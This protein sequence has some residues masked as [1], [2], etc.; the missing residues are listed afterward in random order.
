MF[1]IHRSLLLRCN[2]FVFVANYRIYCLPENQL[3]HN[4]S[5]LICSSAASCIGSCSVF[6][7]PQKIHLLAINFF[8]KDDKPNLEP[9][10][11]DNITIKP[12]VFSHFIDFTVTW[13]LQNVGH[14]TNTAS[15]TWKNVRTQEVRLLFCQIQKFI[16]FTSKNRERATSYLVFNRITKA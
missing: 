3:N 16:E 9:F 7:I 6:R 10:H 15:P 13:A 12:W 1:T 5:L 4:D 2:L 11:S 8:W 14:Y